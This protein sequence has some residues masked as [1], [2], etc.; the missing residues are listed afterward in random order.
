[1]MTMLTVFFFRCWIVWSKTCTA[2]SSSTS[3]VR[4]ACQ[5]TQV[6]RLLI[7]VVASIFEGIG[8]YDG[9]AGPAATKKLSSGHQQH[10]YFD[11]SVSEPAQETKKSSQAG[12]FSIVYG[13]VV[14]GTL[15]GQP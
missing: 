15:L 1:M 2:S 4:T 9:K 7:L 14:T 10:K 3:E 8:D 11:L 6:Y 12:K 5:Y 13:T